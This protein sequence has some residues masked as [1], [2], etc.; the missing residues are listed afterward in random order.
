MKNIFTKEWFYAA[1]VRALRT[2]AQSALAYIGTNALLVTD[3][4]WICVASAG[5]MGALLS[6]LMSLSGLPE[7]GKV[8]DV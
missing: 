6:L 8:E 7:V 1:G 4:N 3:V 5:A 2:F